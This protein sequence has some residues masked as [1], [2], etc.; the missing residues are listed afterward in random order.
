MRRVRKEVNSVLK[1]VLTNKETMRN[2]SR[3]GVAVLGCLMV[4]CALLSAGLTG[5]ATAPKWSETPFPSAPPATDPSAAVAPAPAPEPP[6]V[7]QPYDTIRVKFLYW[8]ELDD[9]QMIRPDGKISL[10]MVGEV[11]AQNRTPGDLQK[12]LLKLYESKLNEPEINVVV[13]SLANN[14]VYVGGEVG[15]PGL[16]L[17]QGRLTALGAIMQAGGFVETSAKKS[18]VVVVRQQNGKQFARTLDLSAELSGTETDPFYL[19]PYDIIFV[20]RTF[21]T[22]V[23]EFVA[24]YIDGV[25][26]KHLNFTMGLY[27]QTVTTSRQK[28]S[29]SLSIPTSAAK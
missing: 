19:Q 15:T 28:V 2:R 12:E 24:Q 22:H 21:I 26:P 25:I 17:I 6:V 5:C 3:I 29:T 10:L 4:C 23:D 14:R 1:P 11:E 16:I 20:P 9:E 8:P 18:S 13:T 7:L 27:N